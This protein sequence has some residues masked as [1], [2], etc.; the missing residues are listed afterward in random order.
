MMQDHC[1]KRE[2]QESKKH[3]LD[4]EIERQVSEVKDRYISSKHSKR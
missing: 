3:L 4:A 1:D 2:V